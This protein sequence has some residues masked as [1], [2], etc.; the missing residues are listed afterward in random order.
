MTT[1]PNGDLDPRDETAPHGAVQHREVEVESNY[2]N[3]EDVDRQ[4][5]WVPWI[6]AAVA[7]VGVG[8]IMF[9]IGRGMADEKTTQPNTVRTTSTVTATPQST[10]APTVTETTKITQPAQTRTSTVTATKNVER[11]ATATVTATQTVKAPQ[12]TVT[13]TMTPVQ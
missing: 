2:D 9:L 13:V 5:S 6:I 12:A 1:T 10:S 4:A 11:T 8:L 7:I 3:A